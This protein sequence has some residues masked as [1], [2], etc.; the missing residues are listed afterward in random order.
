M[1]GGRAWRSDLVCTAFNSGQIPGPAGPEVVF[2]GRSNV[3]KS[4]LINALLGR[5]IAKVSSK[6]GKTR[7]LNFYSVEAK[8]AFFLVDLPGYGYAARGRDER[9]GW[10]RLVNEYF[11]ME[12]D[13]AFVVH[14]VDFRHGPLAND[15]ELTAWLDAMDMPRQVVF[16]KGDKVPRGRRQSTYRTHVSGLA[17]ILPPLVTSGVND[18]EAGRLRDSIEQIIDDLGRQALRGE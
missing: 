18:D 3:G 14:L 9:E 11:G 5:K 17:S 1:T 4:T 8:S 12:R 6:P 2:V 13:I 10:W 16:T 15:D 7:S